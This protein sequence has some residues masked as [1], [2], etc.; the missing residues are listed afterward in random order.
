MDGGTVND[1]PACWDS[2]VVEVARKHPLA[3]A[4]WLLADCVVNW[5]TTVQDSIEEKMRAAVAASGT[6]RS[7]L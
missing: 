1:D 6:C 3:V 5:A 4:A 2:M 7:P